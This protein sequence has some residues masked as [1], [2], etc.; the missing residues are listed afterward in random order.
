MPAS[1]VF[2]S[3]GALCII[4]TQGPAIAAGPK[5]KSVYTT[6]QKCQAVERLQLPE[7][8]LER[9][10]GVVIEYCRGVAN[11]SLYVV[12]EDPRSWLVL[13]RD[14]QLFSLERQMVG[15]FR[16]GYFPNVADAKQVEWLVDQGGR[17]VGLIVRVYYQ[18]ADVS[19]NSAK[20]QASALLAFDLRL[21]E[22]VLLGTTH[23]NAGARGL[24]EKALTSNAH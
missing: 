17:P 23:S 15:E 19:A 6:L 12:D 8:S 2:G 20:A 3:L 4:L 11:Y 1:R 5:F 13:Q 21:L 22:P 16:L 10:Q 18:R 24:V 14:D 9:T 7:R